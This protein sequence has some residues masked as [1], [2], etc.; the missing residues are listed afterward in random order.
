MPH[1]I[2][3]FL[4]PGWKREA[5]QKEG[6]KGKF[7]IKMK[8]RYRGKLPPRMENGGREK[9]LFKKRGGLGQE[10]P[11]KIQQSPASAQ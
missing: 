9:P 10:K 5:C 7:P 4:L 8:S 3:T 11:Q 2:N 6:K 1:P